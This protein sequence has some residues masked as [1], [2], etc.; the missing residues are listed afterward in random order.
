MCSLCHAPVAA[1]RQ[2]RD[3]QP[4]RVAQVLVAVRHGGCDHLDQH[5]LVLPVVS[6]L[7]DPVKVLAIRHLDL[8]QMRHNVTRYKRTLEMSQTY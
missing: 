8:I 4:A 7:T 5:V 1:I 3:D 6:H 2:W